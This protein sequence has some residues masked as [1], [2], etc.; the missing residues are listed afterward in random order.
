VDRGLP[1]DAREE[2]AAAICADAV[3]KYMAHIGTSARRA[4]GY[5]AEQ[6]LRRVANGRFHESRH[7]EHGY[8][9]AVTRAAE[10]AGAEAEAGGAAKPAGGAGG[11]GEGEGR[12]GG[13]VSEGDN[14]GTTDG[15]SRSGAAVRAAMRAKAELKEEI[16]ELKR[17][18]VEAVGADD[19][20]AVAQLGATLEALHSRLPDEGEGKVGAQLRSAGHTGEL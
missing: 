2:A 5:S 18:V 10:E 3:D 8:A 15:M 19:F 11:G 13:E 17:R 9:V 7:N 1:L 4:L 6:Y 16:G 12:D 20:Q 14:D